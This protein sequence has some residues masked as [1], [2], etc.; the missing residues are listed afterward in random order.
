MV[1]FFTNYWAEILLSI[2]TA[3]AL[4]FCRYAYKQIK[5]YKNLLE[6]ENKEEVTNL[7]QNQLQPFKNQIEDISNNLN[8]LTELHTQQA[9]AIISSYKFRLI[10]LCKLYLDQ[11]YMTT[12]QFEQLS[13]MYKVYNDLKGNGQAKKYYERVIE[14]P[15]R[16]EQ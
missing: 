3:G 4:G 12:N 16:D 14:L 6:Q 9:N 7:I 1:N 5:N 10:Q 8:N 11:E 15:I 13:E 2:I